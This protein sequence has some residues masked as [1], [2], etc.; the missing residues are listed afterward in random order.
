MSISDKW[1]DQGAGN[2]FSSQVL[3]KRTWP[4]QL[5]TPIRIKIANN[6]V[7][8]G[9]VDKLNVRTTNDNR[10]IQI[11]G[12]DKTGDL[13]DA[14]A[15]FGDERFFQQ[16]E[17]KNIKLSEIA[18]KFAIQYGISVIVEKGINEDPPFQKVTVRAG[19]SIFQLLDRLAKLRGLLILSN[20]DGDLLITNRAGGDIGAQPD[21]AVTNKVPSLKNVVDKFNFNVSP[22]KKSADVDLIE[23]ENILEAS[24]EF[25]VTD[26]FHRYIVKGQHPGIS[27]VKVLN[28]INAQG[29]ALDNF[30]QRRRTKVIIANGATDAAS[31]QKRANWEMIVRATR[32]VNV[33]I[34]VQG[35]LQKPGGRLWSVNELITLKA[36]MIGLSNRK[37]LITEVTFTKSLDGTFTNLK[38]TRPDAYNVDKESLDLIKDTINDLGHDKTDI[39][40]L[41]AQAAEL[42]FG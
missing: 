36:P 41:A 29:V 7:I 35:W 9:Y 42:I 13:I 38:L 14:S 24:A 3:K 8:T 10:Q 12:R 39:S 26:R 20:E 11:A 18:N 27:G 15:F 22:F 19:E 40:S 34:T 16:V 32:S 21:G 23:G 28:S 4:F 31:A 17:F 30:I 33:N 25:D 6:S 5:G 37:M 1:T 2:P